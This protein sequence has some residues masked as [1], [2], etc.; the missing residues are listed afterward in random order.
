MS[1]SDFSQIFADFIKISAE[2]KVLIMNNP[3]KFAIN[4][5]SS[6]RKKPSLITKP[7][8]L[9]SGLL[10]KYV[11]TAPIILFFLSFSECSVPGNRQLVIAVSKASENY[12]RWLKKGDS[13]LIVKNLYTLSPDSAARVLRQCDGLLL[14]GGEDIQPT[15]YG[16]E[17]EIDGAQKQIQTVTLLN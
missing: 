11:L 10:F 14:T 16:R 12:I 3:R 8:S 4:L 7:R 2:I 5:R 17:D 6:A 9:S 13:L 15:L 1:I